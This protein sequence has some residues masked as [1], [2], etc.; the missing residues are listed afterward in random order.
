M[1]ENYYSLG[2][3]GGAALLSESIAVANLQ[4]EFGDWSKVKD[5]VIKQNILQARTESTMKTLYWEVQRR[6]KHLR[7]EELELLSMGSDEQQKKIVWLAICR[8]YRFIN[9]FAIEV[10]C[11]H[12][13]NAKYE[14][15]TNDFDAFF[16]AKAE[17]HSNLDTLSVQTKNKARQIVFR[18]MRECGLLNEKKGIIPQRL[19]SQLIAF[20]QKNNTDQ[21]RI[22]PGADT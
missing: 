10:V 11:E 9:D 19:D 8:Y 6:L 13:D 22:F 16:N 4:I 15:L 2:F 12:F 21:I 1:A 17:W 5:V 3:T 7:A 20:V 18:M 14:L